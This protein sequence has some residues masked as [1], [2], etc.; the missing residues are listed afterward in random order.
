LLSLQFLLP[1]MFFSHIRS[2]L[3]FTFPSYLSSNILSSLR[4]SLRILY[5]IA[6]SSYH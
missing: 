5:E 2:R 6:I 3:T 4:S 1:R